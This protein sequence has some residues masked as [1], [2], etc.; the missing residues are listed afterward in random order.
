[1]NPTGTTQITNLLTSRLYG[2]DGGYVLYTDGTKLYAWSAPGGSQVILDAVP[3]FAAISGKTVDFVNGANRAT[4][5][6]ITLP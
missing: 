6:Q 2:A 5:Y 3:D 1:L 4:Y